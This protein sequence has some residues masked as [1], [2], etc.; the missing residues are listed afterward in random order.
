MRMESPE[1]FIID[2]KE[3]NAFASSSFFGKTPV[4][5]L[6]SGLVD[7]LTRPQLKAVVA[8]EIGHHKH[9][10]VVRNMHIALVTS[11]LGG[12]SVRSWG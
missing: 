11:S 8:H 3:P 9:R 5:V 1:T 2:R 7:V 12:I 10:D 6:T 4:V